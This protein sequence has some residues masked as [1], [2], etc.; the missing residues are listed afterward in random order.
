MLIFQGNGII[1]RIHAEMRDVKTKIKARN[2]VILK[3]E[4]VITAMKAQ[5]AEL[6][7]NIA[8]FV[9]LT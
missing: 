6:S 2:E 8:S 1:S 5:T 4:S 7:A 9:N 3:Q